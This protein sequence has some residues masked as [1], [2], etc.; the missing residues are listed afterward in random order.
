M[1]ML[2]QTCGLGIVA[3][4]II[5]Q[6]ISTLSACFECV[7]FCKKIMRSKKLKVGLMFP[8]LCHKLSSAA[9]VPEFRGLLGASARGMRPIARGLVS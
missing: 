2:K 1:R 9:P 3:I 6:V 5:H 7:A 4:A 8:I